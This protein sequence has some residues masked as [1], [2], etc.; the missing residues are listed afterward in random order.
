MLRS[1]S[2]ICL[3]SETTEW[4]IMKFGIE[5]VGRI[6][7]WFV[8]AHLKPNYNIFTPRFPSVGLKLML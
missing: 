7:F 2:I 6:Y 5:V 8:S 3:I 4:I 1:Y